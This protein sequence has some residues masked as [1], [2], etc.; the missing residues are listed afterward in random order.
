MAS[1]ESL[2]LLSVETNR[3]IL[4]VLDKPKT[5][6]EIFEAIKDIAKVKN[7]ESVYKALEKLKETGIIEKKYDDQMKNIIYIRRFNEIR[8]DLDEMKINFVK[9]SKI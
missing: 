5:S 7:R 9:E 4:S 2:R 1:F 6:T 8:I 3:V